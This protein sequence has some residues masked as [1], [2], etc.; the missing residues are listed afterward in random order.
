MTASQN[1]YVGG[2]QIDAKL[3]LS[4]DWKK[5]GEKR[6]RPTA[7]DDLSEQE[8]RETDPKT[9]RHHHAAIYTIVNGQKTRL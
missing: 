2:K 3:I 4:D 9:P 6:R 5:T 8:N 1:I 7:E